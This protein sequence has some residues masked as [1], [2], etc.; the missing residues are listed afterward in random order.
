[1]HLLNV[2]V[3]E[4]MLAVLASLLALELRGV[5]APSLPKMALTSRESSPSCS[6]R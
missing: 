5:D 2:S 3:V 6:A 1:M 4:S